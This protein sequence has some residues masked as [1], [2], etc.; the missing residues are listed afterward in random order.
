MVCMTD[1][2][3]R[4]KREYMRK[5]R[6]EHKESTAISNAKYWDKKAREMGLAD[7]DQ[8]TEERRESEAV[9]VDE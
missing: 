8:D 4:A 6:A 2:A 9:S 3:R 7:S 1:S 5:W